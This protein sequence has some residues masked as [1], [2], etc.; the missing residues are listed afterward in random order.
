MLLCRI[1]HFFE[2]LLSCIRLVD[3]ALCRHR[4]DVSSGC[5]QGP[6]MSASADAD[7]GIIRRHHGRIMRR[8][9]H[10]LTKRVVTVAISHCNV[11]S[12]TAHPGMIHSSLAMHRCRPI[13]TGIDQIAIN[14]HW[15]QTSLSSCL[16]DEI[17]Q[18][19]FFRCGLGF[20]RVQ[21]QQEG[22]RG[23]QTDCQLFLNSHFSFLS[24]FLRTFPV[25]IRIEIDT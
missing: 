2:R 10:P 18:S 25:K 3:D 19:L 6:I 9:V 8:R 4:N 20:D 11:F 21:I 5:L 17:D 14:D 1:I 7:V 24:L 22:K 23:S 16:I 15:S 12:S 13:S